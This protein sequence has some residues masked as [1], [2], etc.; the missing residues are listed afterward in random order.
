MLDW[1][2]KLNEK[3]NKK[4]NVPGSVSKPWGGCCDNGPGVLPL[5]GDLTSSFIAPTYD[6]D[7]LGGR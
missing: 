6:N 1:S 2:N 7:E 4:Q 3:W 5:P